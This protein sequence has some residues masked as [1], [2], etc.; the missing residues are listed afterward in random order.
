MTERADVLW[1]GCFKQHKAFSLQTVG[2]A[3]ESWIFIII[4][5][6][7][8]FIII[9]FLLL[10]KALILYLENWHF[11]TKTEPK[12]LT[13]RGTNNILQSGFCPP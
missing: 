7:I 8:S 3:C 10:W 9:F 13:V 2:K 11:Q 12:A 5:D 6:S 4:I 1:A